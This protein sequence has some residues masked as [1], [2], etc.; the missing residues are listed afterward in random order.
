M[1]DGLGNAE[2]GRA[3]RASGTGGGWRAAACDVVVE[4]EHAGMG[5]PSAC[6]PHQMACASLP[7]TACAAA[8]HAAQRGSAAGGA[9]PNAYYA[10]VSTVRTHSTARRASGRGPAVAA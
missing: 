9:M 8:Q 4:A 2:G 1:A 3:R 10:T 5:A 7:E 6:R